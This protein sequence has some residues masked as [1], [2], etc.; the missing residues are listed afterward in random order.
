MGLHYRV[1]TQFETEEQ[2][3]Q[4]ACERYECY[5]V[6]KDKLHEFSGLSDETRIT[7][8]ANGQYAYGEDVFEAHDRFKEKYPGVMS[9]HYFRL[10]GVR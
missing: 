1:E 8:T 2:A 7:I 3:Y 5:K 10:G 4:S 9:R 6:L